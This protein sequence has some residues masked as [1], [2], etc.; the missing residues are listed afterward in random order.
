MNG[1]GLL[2]IRHAETDLAGSFCGSS[3]PAVNAAGERQIAT[4]LETLHTMPCEPLDIVYSSDL[5][6]ALTTAQRVADCFSAQLCILPDLREIHLGE[7]EALTWQ[8]IEQ[9]DPIYAQQWLN[10]YP[11]RPAPGGEPVDRFEARVLSTF[12]TL[13]SCNERAAIV[14]HA[15]VLRVILTR[16]SMMNDEEAW[17][18]TSAYCSVFHYPLQ[19]VVDDNG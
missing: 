8:Q 6:R 3:N 13:T 14:T 10:V 11:T 4:L 7:W 18:Q 15:G 17:H 5:Q 1:G 9:R 19:E 16:R 2:L 12:D